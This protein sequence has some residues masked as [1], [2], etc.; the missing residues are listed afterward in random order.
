MPRTPINYKN[1][2]IYKIVCNDID[3]TECYVGHTTN[4]NKRKGA[5]KS[6]CNNINSKAHHLNV[7]NFIRLNGDW[8]N[9]NMIEIEKYACDNRN[10]AEKRERHF[11]EICEAKLNSRIPSRTIEENREQ[12]STRIKNNKYKIKQYRENNIDKINEQKKKY[13]DNNKDRIRMQR[14]VNKDAINKQRKQ[15][16]EDNKEKLKEERKK[17]YRIKTSTKNT[18]TN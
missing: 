12:N 17:Y 9:W 8:D 16:R 6:N 2:I 11:I 1:T 10:E 13:R 7:Y 15:Y 3:I 14:D 18:N 4:F 5:H